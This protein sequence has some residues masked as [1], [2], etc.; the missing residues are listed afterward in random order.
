V[1]WKS[2]FDDICWDVT[3]IISDGVVK[4]YG[5]PAWTE[6]EG[7]AAMLVYRDKS[8]LDA[9]WRYHILAVQQI[10][11]HE[12]E[13]GV[14]YDR[15][16]GSNG[17]PREGLMVASHYI[18]PEDEPQWGALRG[19]RTDETVTYFRTAVHEMG[20]AMGLEHNDGGFSFMRPTGGIAERAPADMP[21][22]SNIVWAFAPDDL[23]R[24]RH[25]PDIYVRP[26]GL[27][28]GAGKLSPLP[29]D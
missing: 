27:Y 14:M 10:D 18:F 28:W 29:A 1:S 21:F 23:H 2:V 11:V 9:E 25:W 6:D 26:G 7:H 17:V 24:L 12:G 5:G 16:G 19:I 15:S 3:T 13:R 8:D 20:H 22:P 4:K